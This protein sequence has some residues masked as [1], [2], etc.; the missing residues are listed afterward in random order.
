M[1]PTS[2]R[3]FVV[4]CLMLLLAECTRSPI[5]GLFEAA[6]KGDVTALRRSLDAGANINARD[7]EH[8]ATALC[9]AAWYGHSDAVRFLVDAGADVNAK[10]HC[11]R[12][13]LIGTVVVANTTVLM[14]AAVNGHTSAVQALVDA[15]ADVNTKNVLGFTPLMLA[16]RSGNADAVKALLKAGADVKAEYGAALRWASEA[17]HTEIV[18]LLKKAEPTR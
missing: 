14:Y 4:C 18:E 1:T 3:M 17:G 11:G 5:R 8:G 10:D 6:K 2:M 9:H 7:E 16:V 12:V 13:A 15:G